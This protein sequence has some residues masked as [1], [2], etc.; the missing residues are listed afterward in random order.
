MPDDATRSHAATRSDFASHVGWEPIKPPP[1]TLACPR[2][3]RAPFECL[4]KFTGRVYENCHLRQADAT[5]SH[6]ADVQRSRDL[7]AQALWDLWRSGYVTLD[8][9]RAVGSDEVAESMEKA[10]SGA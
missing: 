6:A 4:E 7:M 10:A 3:C 5:R 2:G 1:A 8:D 9:L